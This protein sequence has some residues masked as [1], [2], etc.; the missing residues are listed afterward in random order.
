MKSIEVHSLA[1]EPGAT[2]PGRHTEDGEDVSPELGWAGLPEGAV[3]LALI[4]DDPD[5]PTDEPWVHWVIYKIP[6]DIAALAEGVPYAEALSAP[7][8]ALQGRNTWGTVGYRGPAPPK[9][10][11]T[12]HYHFKL[13]A[14]D[15]ALAVEPGLDKAA[16]LGAMDGHILGQGDLIGTY[17]R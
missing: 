16:L 13:Y 3:E 12:H 15:R 4:V 1:F 17:E 8:G 10:H 11:G 14:L 5:A 9:G 7:A 2:I 6:P